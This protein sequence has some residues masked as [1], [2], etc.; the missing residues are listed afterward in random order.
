REGGLLYIGVDATGNAVGVSDADKLQL[1]IKDRLKHNILPSCLG[2]FDIIAVEKDEKDIIK[3]MVASGPEKPYHLRK[4][5]MSEKGTFIRT[6]SAAEPMP[7]KMIN[8]LFAKRTR[9]SIGKIKSN[10]QDLKF[11]QLK[12]YYE[13]AAKSLNSHFSKTLDLHTE[14]GAFNYVAYLLADTNSVSIKVAKYGGTDKSDLEQNEEY[15]FCSLIK[16]TNRVLDKLEVENKTYTKI[17]GSAR[18]LERQMIDKT[19]LREALINA[20]VHNDYTREV[21]PVVE[22]YSD[23]LSITS[24]GGLVEGLSLD[25]F[26]D[27]RSIPRNRELMRVF[28]DVGLVEHLGSGIHR[29]LKK[30]DRSI[31]KISENFVEISFPFEVE[32]NADA[33][34]DNGPIG[35]PIGGLIGGPIELTERQN[36]ILELIRADKRLTKRKLAELLKINVSAVQRHLDALK[37]KKAIKRM[38]GTRGYWEIMVK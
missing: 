13:G 9:A 6:G 8:E 5:G 1:K 15:G 17:T 22:I 19:A 25:E 24:Y 38:G 32:Y 21:T 30:Y 4:Y 3:I 28:R 27:G 10:R 35:G 36:Q 31:F 11:N 12:I 37:E 7:A 23:R 16:A 18:R 20:M 29:I 34:S 14:D 33:G 26:F 2:L